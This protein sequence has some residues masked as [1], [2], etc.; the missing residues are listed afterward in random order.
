MFFIPTYINLNQPGDQN[1]HCSSTCW[2]NGFN[3]EAQVHG[4][5][6]TFDPCETRSSPIAYQM[7]KAE[8]KKGDLF[9]TMF[10]SNIAQ[11]Q[12]LKS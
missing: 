2:P 11:Y 5:Q 4:I 8:K 1:D 7:V 10:F 6:Q 3:L 9:E 12:Y